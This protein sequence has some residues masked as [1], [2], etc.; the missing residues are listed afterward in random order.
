MPPKLLACCSPERA[1]ISNST[2]C[3]GSKGSGLQA[4]G[5]A[6]RVQSPP[7]AG[8]VDFQLAGEGDIGVVHDHEGGAGLPQRHHVMPLQRHKA[9]ALQ[10]RVLRR[11]LRRH[12]GGAAPL[13]AALGCAS[14]LLRVAVGCPATRMGWG[15][16]R[17][18][19]LQVAPAGGG[20]HRQGCCRC[21]SVGGGAL[22]A[23]PAPPA[24]PAAPAG[25][26]G[27]PPAT[28]ARARRVEGR[29]EIESQGP[30]L[31]KG[32]PQKLGQPHPRTQCLSA[33]T[34]CLPTC[35]HWRLHPRHRRQ[36]LPGLL[37]P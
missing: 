10:Q 5:L 14:Q 13:R 12:C 3:T 31:T 20:C 2:S 15:R 34:A 21:R 8:L 36:A 29:S 24:P 32:C 35:P 33:A 11:L 16:G 26:A 7:P 23:A 30:G 28:P 19:R 17:R 4:T 6:H 1:C 27:P 37:P 9:H 22:P 18:G 25:A